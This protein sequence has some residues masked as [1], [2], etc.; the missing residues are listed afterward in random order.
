MRF[1]ASAY[2]YKLRDCAQLLL[3]SGSRP[4]VLPKDCMQF[5]EYPS[6]FGGEGKKTQTASCSLLSYAIRRDVEKTLLLYF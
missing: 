3:G 5:R 4:T 2:L 1:E 6:S